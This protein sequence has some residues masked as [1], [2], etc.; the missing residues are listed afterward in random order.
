MNYWKLDNT[1]KAVVLVLEDGTLFR[2]LAVDIFDA[3]YENLRTIG[4]EPVNRPSSDLPDIHFESTF[5]PLKFS[6]VAQSNEIH[7]RLGISDVIEES[8]SQIPNGDQLIINNRWFVTSEDELKSWGSDLDNQ[9]ISIGT[10]LDI[11]QILWLLW[12]WEVNVDSDL[13]EADYAKAKSQSSVSKFNSGLLKANLYPYQVSGSQFLTRNADAGIGAVLADEMGLGK[14]MQAIFL[15][16]YRKSIGRT[17]PSLVVVLSSTLANW[18][19][20]LNKFAPQL[21]IYTH[22]GTRRTGDPSLFLM[23]DVVLTSYDTL[24]RDHYLLA[25]VQFSEVVLDEAQAIKN[26]SSQRSRA[27]K[28][29]KRDVS[30]AVTGTPIETSLQDMW[31][32][33]EF[34][35]PELLGTLL[36]FQHSFPDELE[37]A[38]KLS[39]KVAPLTLRRTVAEVA[40]DLP[41]RIDIESPILASPAFANVYNEIRLE[42]LSALVKMLRLRQ[43]CSSATEGSNGQLLSFRDHPKLERLLQIL[44][45]VFN[46]GNKALVFAPFKN[47]LDLLHEAI[48]SVFP[49]V[50]LGIVDGRNT[51]VERQSLID[52]FSNSSLPGALILNPRAAGVGL[53]IQAANYV[54]HFSPEWNPAVVAQAS[55]RSHRRGQVKP[56]FV[57]YMYYKDTVEQVMMDRLSHRREIAAAGM[58]E[59]TDDPTDSEIEHALSLTPGEGIS[60]Q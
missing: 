43:L 11:S 38:S 6:L 16:A 45:E 33:F 52:E 9:R 22:S 44:E 50:Y 34:V 13:S 59:F 58:S 15:L 36:E 18:Q 20:E 35:R 53:N 4:S 21:S 42:E 3:E 17:K 12:E 48:K 47:T 24:T 28:A 26:S 40:K 41:P 32:I 60:P 27:V 49:S 46:G 1:K 31:S 25:S 5:A 10:A 29:L 23:Y 56:V 51:P 30:V 8:L 14:T 7:L 37:A 19:R 55:A 54:I 2:P 57:Y 39:Q